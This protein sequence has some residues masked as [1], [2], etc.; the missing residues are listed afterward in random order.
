MLTAGGAG[1]APVV[2]FWR[3][4]TPQVRTQTARSGQS[5]H[6]RAHSRSLCCDVV[7]VVLAR[8]AQSRAWLLRC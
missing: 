2:I 1:G 8:T 4:R 5:V 3:Q 6:A 7:H